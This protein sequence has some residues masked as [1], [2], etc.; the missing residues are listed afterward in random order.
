M[1][2]AMS[3]FPTAQKAAPVST[4]TLASDF[5]ELAARELDCAKRRCELLQM[6]P[7]AAK[8][9]QHRHILRNLKSSLIDIETANRLQLLSEK[10]HA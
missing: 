9:E 8:H 2:S 1:G 6:I 3:Q 5:R 4:S 10:R 7:A